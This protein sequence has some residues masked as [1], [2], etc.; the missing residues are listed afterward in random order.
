MILSISFF[1]YKSGFIL[2]PPLPPPNGISNKPNYI[3]FNIAVISI[4][5]KLILGYIIIPPLIGNL[6]FL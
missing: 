4:D 1:E 6:C 2:I 3:V 5:S